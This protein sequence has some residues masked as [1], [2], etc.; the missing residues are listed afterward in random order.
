L[1]SA[2]SPRLGADER[3]C[4][5]DDHPAAHPVSVFTGVTTCLVMT[6]LP[7]NLR[8]T[9]GNWYD[10]RTWIEYGLSKLKNLFGHF[11]FSL[12]VNFYMVRGL[13]G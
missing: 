8:H 6:N 3:R 10:L 11:V 1:R 7:S 12:R 2:L 13:Q 4:R 5:P 9:F